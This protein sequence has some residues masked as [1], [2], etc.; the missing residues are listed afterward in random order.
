MKLTPLEAKESF[1]RIYNDEPEIISSAPG[2]INIIGEHTD[3]NRGYV[4]PAA[5]DRSVQFLAKRR[6]DD[7]I[8][9]WSETFQ[10]KKAFALHDYRISDNNRWID[11]VKGIFW[12]LE[13]EG[14]S[15]GGVDGF[16]TGDIPIGSGLSSSAAMEISIIKALDK[17][18]SLSLS[19]EQMA[20]LSQRAENDFVG[21]NCG[22]MDQ[23]I[24]VFG[25][26]ERALFLDCETLR[27]EHIPLL[28]KDHGLHFVVYDTRIQRELSS[29]DYNT[30]RAEAAEALRILSLSGINSYRDADKDSLQA[31]R[32]KMG[33]TLFK[34][35][36]HIINENQ[37]VNDAVNFLKKG[38]FRNLGELLFQSHL[39]LRDDYEVSCPELDLLYTVGSAFEGCLGA[40]L[41]GAGFGGSGIALI[42]KAQ[43]DAFV[44]MIKKESEILQFTPPL[45]YKVEVGEGAV[46]Q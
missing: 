46:V 20:V 26:K 38:D 21:V 31:N 39:S 19:G 10:E 4:L 29:S 25:Q 41:T 16:I 22:L 3:Y 27:Y 33:E 5:I 7:K 2:R 45:F 17:I 6:G 15:L 35:A 37:R 8:S 34:R 36:R 40:R 28:L 30:R 12:V 14:H 24:S 13:Q 11:Y 42:E 44:E 18:F 23:F 9:V 32:N 1:E 43:T